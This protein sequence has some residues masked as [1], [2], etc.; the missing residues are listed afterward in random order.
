[1]NSNKKSVQPKKAAKIWEFVMDRYEL[2]VHTS[3]EI[4]LILSGSIQHVCNGVTT[5][6]TEGHVI[7]LSPNCIHRYYSSGES[8]K[9]INFTFPLELVS[10]D[11]WKYVDMSKVPLIVKPEGEALVSIKDT[12]NSIYSLSKEYRQPLEESVYLKTMVEWLVLKLF[13]CDNSSDMKEDNFS[14]AIMYI[15]NNFIPQ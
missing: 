3:F 9:I 6:L 1:M 10:D 11:V 7:F 2:H 4:T 12:L 14:P 15:H 8:T 13:S 5:T